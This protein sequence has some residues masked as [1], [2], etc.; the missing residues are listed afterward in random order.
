MN[1]CNTTSWVLVFAGEAFGICD[2]AGNPVPVYAPAGDCTGWYPPA[3]GDSAGV[4]ASG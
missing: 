4:L 3:P 2:V 1:A